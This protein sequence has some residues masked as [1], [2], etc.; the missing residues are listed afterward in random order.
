MGRF[1]F[2]GYSFDTAKEMDLAKK[3]AESIEYIKAKMELKNRE[4]ARK[5]YDSL[6]EKQ[7]FVTPIGIQ[8][9][10]EIQQDLSMFSSS[11]LK[12]VPVHLALDKVNKN[13]GKLTKGFIAESIDRSVHQ[14]DI[15]KDKLRNSKIIIT[16]LVVLILAMF[17]VVLLG[18]NSPFQDAE[19]KLQDKY[20]VWEEQLKE[21]EQYLLEKEEQ[22]NLSD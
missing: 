17:A 1:E 18:K 5:L 10:K 2:Q 4:K 3:E 16:F 12:G 19:Q 21:K 14:V 13:Q 22:L 9:M 15:Y 8:F 7:S 11:P 6:V 20:A